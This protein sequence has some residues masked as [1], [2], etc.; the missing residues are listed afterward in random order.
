M[1]NIMTDRNGWMAAPC[2]VTRAAPRRKSAFA[3]HGWL[4]WLLVALLL[5][6]CGASAQQ[7]D[8]PLGTGDV[9]R[10]TVFQHADLTTEARIA[11]SGSITFP[12]IGEVP[13]AGLSA[14]AVERRIAERL[15]SGGFVPQP[16]V[17]VSVVQF[18]SAQVSVLGHVH[19]PGRFPLEAGNYRV[20]DLLAMAGGLTPEAADIVTLATWRSGKEAR[21]EIDIPAIMKKGELSKDLIVSSG[22]TIY[23]PRAPVF[24]I[25]GEVQRPGQYRVERDMTLLQALAVGGGL[26]QRGTQRGITVKRRNP[27]GAVTEARPP[28]N[29]PILPDDVIYVRESLF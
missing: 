6:A 26:T 21:F 23:V 9:I 24:Y 3:L 29:W 18:R 19:R 5:F 13:V 4:A 14:A 22:D 8:L 7:K 25:Y 12:L 27:G 1:E 20:T 16:Q 15:K 11:E 28:L 10:I 17:N 2:A